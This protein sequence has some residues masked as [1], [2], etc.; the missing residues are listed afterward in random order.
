MSNM[1][2]KEASTLKTAT[3]VALFWCA[4][5]VTAQP[6]S[7][8]LP[9]SLEASKVTPKALLSGNGYSVGN[10]VSNDGFQ[11]T[12]SVKSDYGNSTVT[13]NGALAARK[14]EIRAIRLLE[15]IESSDAFKEGVKG[16][17]SDI[18]EGGKSL[19]KAPVETTKG[20]AKGVGRWLGNVG[21]SITSD[22]PHQDN[23]GKTL[24]G[25]DGVKRAYAV[26]LGVDP[27]TDF[28]PFL[29]RLTRVARAATAGGLTMSM[30]TD[31][32]T[33]GTT[34]GT[35]IMVTSTANMKELLKDEPPSALAKINK[36]KLEGMGIAEHNSNALLKNYNYTPMQMTIMVEALKRMGDIDGH[37]IFVAYATAAPDGL[38]ARYVQESAEMLANYIAAN[39]S[40]NI[41]NIDDQAWFLTK[42]GKL[43][44]TFPIDYLAWTDIL[45][46]DARV[47]DENEKKIGYKSK[48]L[49]VEG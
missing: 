6:T 28:E 26:E 43:V 29:E 10:A 4:T 49:L 19:V 2:K 16:S 32:A 42:S 11:N 33:Q 23:V 37:D 12:Y 5:S 39:E 34:V 38:I 7:Q 3:L 27:N 41:V 48:E 18:V 44:G 36:A 24:L 13:G 1:I 35:V 14:M 47:I 45:A 9:L 20:A 46:S 30:V 22:D 8:Q 40:G 31:A 15:E 21:R 17:A 25:Y